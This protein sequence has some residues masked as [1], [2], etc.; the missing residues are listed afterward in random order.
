MLLRLHTDSEFRQNTNEHSNWNIKLEITNSISLITHFSNHFVSDKNLC[1]FIFPY[2]TSIN[3]MISPRLRICS[4]KIWIFEKWMFV[5]RAEVFPSHLNANEM[6]RLVRF[7]RW[8]SYQFLTFSWAQEQSAITTW[9]QTVI[10]QMQLF[11]LKGVVESTQVH[12]FNS[13]NCF[14]VHSHERFSKFTMG[15]RSILL[16][17]PEKRKKKTK[18]ERKWEMN[19]KEEKCNIYFF[20]LF[21]LFWF[22]FIKCFTDLYE[23]NNT[24]GLDWDVFGLRR[25]EGLKE[26]AAIRTGQNEKEIIQLRWKGKL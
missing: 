24:T 21:S 11:R 14:H 5:S 18:M 6:N 22:L 1:I 26:R 3:L 7:P 25:I 13:K 23:W 10:Q 16:L 15:M 2:Q 8:I 4:I 12:Y 9:P 20:N 19:I 17:L